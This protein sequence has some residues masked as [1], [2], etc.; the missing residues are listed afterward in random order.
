MFAATLEIVSFDLKRPRGPWLAL[1]IV[2]AVIA[3]AAIVGLGPLA[4][5]GGGGGSSD[6]CGID[7]GFKEPTHFDRIHSAD[8]RG[9]FSCR[10]A[11]E[12][13]IEKDPLKGADAR[14]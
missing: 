4:A 5:T 11:G 7:T 12:R 8:K 3:V 6:T 13:G 2:V 1:V 10:A 14:R 9:S